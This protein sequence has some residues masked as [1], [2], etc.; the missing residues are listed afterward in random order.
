MLI[1]F[2]AQ[3]ETNCKRINNDS[4]QSYEPMVK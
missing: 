2:T 4:V 1:P 3:E